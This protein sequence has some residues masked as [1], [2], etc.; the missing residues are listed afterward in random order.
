MQFDM[1]F[2]EHCSKRS[3]F[4]NYKNLKFFV[5]LV[6]SIKKSQPESFKI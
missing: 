1:K 3:I 4:L 6:E 5:N 2:N